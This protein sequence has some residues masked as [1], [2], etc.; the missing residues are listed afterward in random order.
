M[1]LDNFLYPYDL[2]MSPTGLDRIL[3]IGSCLSEFYKDNFLRINPSLSIDFLLFNGVG[4][5]PESP[6]APISQYDLIYVQ[7]PMRSVLGDG[8]VKATNFN[9]SDFLDDLSGSV[10][11][12]LRLMLESA[13]KYTDQ[14][15]VF[16]LVS[17]FIVPQGHAAPS[18]A[19]FHSSVDLVAIID[20]LN[21]ELYALIKE[22]GNVYLADV[23]CIA[24]SIGKRHFSD[25]IIYMYSHGGTYGNSEENLPPWTA[26]LPGRIEFVPSVDE[27][28]TGRTVEFAKCVYR[29][30][31]C[32]YRIA[33]QIDQVKIVIFDLDNTLWRGEIG[34]HYGPGMEHPHYHG[35]PLGIWEAIHHLRWRG[36]LVAICSKNSLQIVEE[37]WDS[38]VSLPFIKLDDF[39]AK[40][41]NW[42][43]K[44]E[45]IQE[46]LHEVSLTARSAVFVDDNPVER[47]A[48]KAA[49]QDMRVIG[50]DP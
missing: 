50:S 19:D 37:R 40:K 45:N 8:V 46:I 5:L 18:M 49:Y 17:N 32:L 42:K 31:E 25:D 14:S 33:K 29:Q 39:A 47:N 24:N 43:T 22:H 48:V 12:A 26:P 2:Q 38:A 35:W 11:A 27:T 34:D 21:R 15:A 44:A 28:Y 30:I 41:I 3:L 23:D 10:S 13:L 7:L 16:T 36:I 9:N 6:P 1:E 4:D 20:S